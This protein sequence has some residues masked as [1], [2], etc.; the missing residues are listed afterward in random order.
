[1]RL[2]VRGRAGHDIGVRA[3]GGH[4]ID[5]VAGIGA[6]WARRVVCVE[7]RARV[8]HGIRVVC[9]CGRV[10][11]TAG[12][13]GGLGRERARCVYGRTNSTIWNRPLRQD[14]VMAFLDTSQIV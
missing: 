11:G 5:A 3:R 12:G 4:G 1:M 2:Q 9:G 6:C 7:V 8:G 10:P 14:S 13:A